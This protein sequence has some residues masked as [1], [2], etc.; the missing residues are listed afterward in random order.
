[1]FVDILDLIMYATFGDDRLRP[2]GVARGRISGFSIEI[3]RRPYNALALPCG[4]VI[5]KDTTRKMLR[6]VEFDVA[7]G[8]GDGGTARPHLNP[9]LNH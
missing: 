9:L 6:I 4:C 1:M 2:K 7:Q 8:G 5:R 3:R